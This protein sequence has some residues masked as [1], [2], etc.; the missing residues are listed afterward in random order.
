MRKIFLLFCL[1]VIVA[2]DKYHFLPDNYSEIFLGR[3]KWFGTSTANSN[4]YQSADSAGYTIK[5]IFDRNG[6]YHYFKNDTLLLLTNYS[7]H[8]SHSY[9]GINH[10]LLRLDKEA[11]GFDVYLNKFSMTDILVIAGT[12]PDSGESYYLKEP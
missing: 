10:Y 9:N 6:K 12:Y 5:I 11:E 2:C 1:V 3:W 7:F 8:Y 4:S